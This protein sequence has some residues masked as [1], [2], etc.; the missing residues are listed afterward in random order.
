MFAGFYFCGSLEKLQKLEPAEISRHTVYCKIYM[1]G[2]VKDCDS[3]LEK[4]FLIRLS[5][6]TNN[7][8]KLRRN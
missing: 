3:F 4:T 8:A 7:Y 6:D 5:Y 2:V 1:I